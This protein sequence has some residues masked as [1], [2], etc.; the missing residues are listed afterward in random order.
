[1]FPVVPLIHDLVLVLA[2]TVGPV[3]SAVPA[4]S[5]RLGVVEVERPPPGY[6]AAKPQ[7]APSHA[8]FFELPPGAPFLTPQEPIT[9]ANVAIAEYLASIN[10]GIATPMPTGRGLYHDTYVVETVAA[11]RTTVSLNEDVM[12]DA[13]EEVRDDFVR[14]WIWD[15]RLDALLSSPWDCELNPC[16]IIGFENVR[17]LARNELERR[18]RMIS[19]LQLAAGIVAL[20]PLLLLL[21]RLAGNW[22]RALDLRER[23]L[24]LEEWRTR[25]LN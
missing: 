3:V 20:L 2:M 5:T 13:F 10:P 6:E 11:D 22:K 18:G 9:S 1:M 8:A 24:Q 23:S 15:G 16:R 7:A 17:T 4:P 14:T 12:R 19:F 21:L 25:L